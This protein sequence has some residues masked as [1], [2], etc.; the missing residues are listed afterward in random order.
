LREF[1]NLQSECVAISQLYK[2]V[3][4]LVVEQ[5]PAVEKI[6][7]NVEVTEIQVEEG[8]RHLQQA[9]SYKT[10][11]Y[12]LVGGFVGACLLGPVGLI[13]GLKAGSAATV[14]GG[15]CGYAGGKILKKTNSPTTPEVSDLINDEVDQSPEVELAMK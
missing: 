9:L 15:L 14:C 8:R 4:E 3:H 5:A 2:N 1:E 6:A 12:P 10:T 13:A 7:E 11:M